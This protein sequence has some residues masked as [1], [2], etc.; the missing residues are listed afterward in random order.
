MPVPYRL[1]SAPN[2]AGG[3]AAADREAGQPIHPLP[4][5]FRKT[6]IPVPLRYR[7]D[8]WWSQLGSNQ[9]PFRCERNALPLSHG[10]VMLQMATDIRGCAKKPS[11]TISGPPNP[12]VAPPLGHR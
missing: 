9:R 10:T 12:Q 7:D 3:P 1:E 8:L 11:M 4:T 5:N 2:P 6:K